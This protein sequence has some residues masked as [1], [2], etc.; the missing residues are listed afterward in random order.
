M[1]KFLVTAKLVT[2]C[3][4]EIEAENYEEAWAQA[5][6][7]DAGSFV[8]EATPTDWEIYTVENV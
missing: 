1:T 3:T 2:K 8:P 4:L 7:A 6:A 5:R